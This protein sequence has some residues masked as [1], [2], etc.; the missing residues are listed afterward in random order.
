MQVTIRLYRQHDMDL[1]ALYRT[2]GFRF[3]KT[4]KEAVRAFAANADFHIKRP[5]DA[6]IEE[7]YVPKIVQMHI[8]LDPKKDREAIK[9]LKEIRY[10]YRSSFLKALFRKYLTT[11][12][13]DAYR[14]RDDLIFDAEKDYLEPGKK[15]R[16]E[17]TGRQAKGSMTNGEKPDTSEVQRQRHTE[18]TQKQHSA[19]SGSAGPEGHESDSQKPETGQRI[20]RAPDM[21]EPDHDREFKGHDTGPGKDQ[22]TESCQISVPDGRPEDRKPAPDIKKDEKNRE[23][24]TNK[25]TSPFDLFGDNDTDGTDDYEEIMKAMNALAH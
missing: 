6:P 20:R 12:P 18:T 3:Q 1:V 21:T 23:V 4:M 19:M 24:G 8:M 10:G 16:A 25:E 17:K 11:E 15:S 5:K 7:G 2:E 9:I 22:N 13:L 14:D